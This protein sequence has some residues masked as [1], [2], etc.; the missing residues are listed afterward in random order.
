MPHDHRARKD[1]GYVPQEVPL[2]GNYPLANAKQGQRDRSTPGGG[3]LSRF[4]P[5]TLAAALITPAAA[6]KPAALRILRI[7]PV[8]ERIGPH[9]R[10]ARYAWRLTL[11]FYALC[12]DGLRQRPIRRAD[13]PDRLRRDDGPCASGLS[14]CFPPGRGASALRRIVMEGRP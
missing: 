1:T 4:S 11:R 13:A 10:D 2:I 6:S 7:I 12:F 8:P 14:G 9:P 3:P 5:S